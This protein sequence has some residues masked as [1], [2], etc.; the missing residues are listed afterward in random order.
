[1]KRR[2]AGLVAGLVAPAVTVVAVAGCSGGA[3]VADETPRAAASSSPGA[4]SDDTAPTPSPVDPGAPG[5]GTTYCRLL[6]T[7]LAGL[8]AG[9]RG[10]GDVDRAIGLVRRIAD[11]APPQVHDEWQTM[12]GA[13]DELRTALVKAAALQEQAAAGQVDPERLRE[14]AGKLMKDMQ[15]LDTPRNN[16]A[17]DTVAAQARRYCGLEI[18]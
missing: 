2:L 15:A 6:G 18:G 17:G 16:R 4:A 11:E 7:D 9:I 10:P 3:P 13:L 1:M 8:F 14:Q 5:A 12:A